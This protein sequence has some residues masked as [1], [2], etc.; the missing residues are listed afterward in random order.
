[1]QLRDPNPSISHPNCWGFF[2]GEIEQAETS[3]QGA[4]R[5]IME[6]LGLRKYKLHYL[7]TEVSKINILTKEKIQHYI[8]TSYLR[9]NLA[10]LTL[11]EGVD[12]KLVGIGQFRN[13]K[14]YSPKTKQTH[15]IARNHIISKYFLLAQ[16]LAGRHRS[17]LSALNK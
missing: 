1:M 12:M 9:S 11:A 3:R 17:G 14:I 5:E 13:G 4:H 8:Y 2:G 15:L 16:K 10:D 7:G 6:E